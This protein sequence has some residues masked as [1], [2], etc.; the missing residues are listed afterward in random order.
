MTSWEFRCH[1]NREECGRPS[2][3]SP[4]FSWSL[5][6]AQS[7]WEAGPDSVQRGTRLPDWEEGE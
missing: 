2:G 5:M 3:G 7:S 6:A 4:K 1:G